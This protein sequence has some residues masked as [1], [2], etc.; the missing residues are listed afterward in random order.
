MR[1][2]RRRDPHHHIL[3]EAPFTGH[4]SLFLEASWVFF[5][6]GR[7]IS[8]LR[9]SKTQHTYRELLL[10]ASNDQKISPVPLYA[11]RFF[12]LLGRRRLNGSWGKK[13]FPPSLPSFWPN[14]PARGRAEG[15]SVGSLRVCGSAIPSNKP[16][17]QEKTRGLFTSGTCG[18]NRVNKILL[19]IPWVSY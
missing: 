9:T 8:F 17:Q 18:I 15:L 2:R 19:V 5:V 3:H 4:Q 10:N 12:L 7:E 16:T 6:L 11:R 1:R 14:P 13:F